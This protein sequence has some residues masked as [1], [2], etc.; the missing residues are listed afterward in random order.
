[1]ITLDTR[2]RAGKDVLFRNLGGES[3]LLNLQTGKYYGLD[4]VGTRM[5]TLLTEYGQVEPAFRAL[6]EEY[7]VAEDQ[8]QQDLC[9]FVEELISRQL[10]E[11]H[12]T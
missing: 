6:L 12:E 3:V 2:V 9:R 7:D 1:M 4:E 8:L 5:W 10:L 11:I